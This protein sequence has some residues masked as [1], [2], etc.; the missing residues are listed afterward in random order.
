MFK[1]S[2]LEAATLLWGAWFVQANKNSYFWAKIQRMCNLGVAWTCTKHMDGCQKKSSPLEFFNRQFWLKKLFLLKFSM[3]NS[4]NLVNSKISKYFHSCFVPTPPWSIISFFG[5]V[6]RCVIRV[7][8]LCPSWEKSRL[9]PTKYSEWC[10][11][12]SFSLFVFW[13]TQFIQAKTVIYGF[14]E[15]A[16]LMSFFKTKNKAP[17]HKKIFTKFFPKHTKLRYSYVSFISGL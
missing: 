11:P 15:T 13:M 6:M 7:P 8:S 14:P 1:G 3:E 12:A 2:L 17:V 16:K 10:F 5:K 9:K 4:G